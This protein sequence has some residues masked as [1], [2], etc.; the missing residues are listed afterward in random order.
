M[1]KDDY[2][3][4]FDSIK[5]DRQLLKTIL[6]KADAE[7]VKVVRFKHIYRYAAS[8]AAVFVLAG[9]VFLF[10]NGLLS[11]DEPATDKTDAPL[12]SSYNT[13]DSKAPSD[14]TGIVAEE[15][16]ETELNTENYNDS[17]ENSESEAS[18]NVIAKNNVPEA[19]NS[20][21]NNIASADT[22]NN[23]NITPSVN[24]ESAV[25]YN[26]A[27]EESYAADK[28]ADMPRVS[29]SMAKSA[30]GEASD[31]L[32][33]SSDSDSMGGGGGNSSNSM[34]GGRSSARASESSEAALDNAAGNAPMLASTYASFT[35]IVET[36][37]LPRIETGEK[38]NSSQGKNVLNIIKEGI[39]ASPEVSSYKENIIN[40]KYTGE[41]NKFIN[42]YYSENPLN[43]TI[44]NKLEPSLNIYKN[45]SSYFAYFESDCY[46]Y[47]ATENISEDYMT[48]IV[49]TLSNAF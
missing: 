7:P 2:K 25:L 1:F 27:E 19:Q 24:Q 43:V 28:E 40:E 21:G 45:G 29:S 44:D 46:Y 5:G 8:V 47:I 12:Q 39:S 31:S 6:E 15:N 30:S 3:N 41:D 33:G 13:E 17:A 49:E 23:K 35:N 16:T 4:C 18:N 26:E 34:G 36:D 9:T 48:E 20:S 38:T 11:Y 42:I 14:D 32:S 37:I 10:N 22:G